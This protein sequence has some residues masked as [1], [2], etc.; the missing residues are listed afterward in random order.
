MYDQIKKRFNPE[1]RKI[2]DAIAQFKTVLCYT[3][4]HYTQL[5]ASLFLVGFLVFTQGSLI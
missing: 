5:V 4:V 2:S 3:L 1:L